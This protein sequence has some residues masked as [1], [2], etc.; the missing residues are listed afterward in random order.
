MSEYDLPQQ[1]L[2]VVICYF[3]FPTDS[4]FYATPPTWAW[5]QHQKW[6]CLWAAAQQGSVEGGQP[7]A[8]ASSAATPC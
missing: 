3:P 5:T 8:Q 7:V 4:Q 6:M 1:S 2:R